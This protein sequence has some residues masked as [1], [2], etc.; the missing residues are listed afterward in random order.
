M[1]DD[2]APPPTVF[3]PP[4]LSMVGGRWVSN[5]SLPPP[6]APPPSAPPPSAPPP[7]AIPAPPPSTAEPVHLVAEAA[8]APGQTQ[9][10]PGA[11]APLVLTAEQLA[12]VREK[13]AAARR[14]DLPARMKDGMAEPFT[15][16]ALQ[17]QLDAAFV[18]GW[19]ACLQ[20]IEALNTAAEADVT[21]RPL[22]VTVELHTPEATASAVKQDVAATAAE[23]QAQWLLMHWAPTL[24][25][26]HP[27][28]VALVGRSAIRVQGMQSAEQPYESAAAGAGEA[29]TVAAF[30]ETWRKA[31]VSA[32]KK[33]AVEDLGLMDAAALLASIPEVDANGRG[34]QDLR[35]M[36]K[37][38]GVKAAFCSN[39]HVLLVGPAPKLSKKCFALRNLL[40]HYHWRLSGRDVAF[41]TMTQQ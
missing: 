26:K 39:Q 37:D 13:L 40:S 23:G 3:C 18:M 12:A 20:A 38:L 33:V 1:G 21:Q 34:L 35:A 2:G 32:L 29:E 36:E 24:K 14:E 4:G 9:S 11:P 6:S 30:E 41:E 8:I 7:R 5:S 31:I 15:E 16:R 25:R 19:N 17:K 28:D 22:A 10:S 27:V